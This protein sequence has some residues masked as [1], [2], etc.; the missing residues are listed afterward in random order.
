MRDRGDR[1]RPA[2]PGPR[3]RPAAGWG[4]LTPAELQVAQLAASGIS[5]PQ[6]ASRLSMSRNTV[7]MHLSNVY[8]KLHIGNRTELAGVMAAHSADLSPALRSAAGMPAHLNAR[9]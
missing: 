1:L 9:T 8:L 6:I 7:K 3:N 2:H 5:N 4:S